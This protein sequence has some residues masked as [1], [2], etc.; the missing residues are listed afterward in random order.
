[1]HPC[2]AHLRDQESCVSSGVNDEYSSPQRN[3]KASTRNGKGYELH[4][5]PA[6]P[7]NF[8]QNQIHQPSRI[9]E[10][11]DA[12]AR[13]TDNKSCPLEKDFVAILNKIR[14]E[15]LKMHL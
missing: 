8:V 9:A 4:G 2:Q 14:F 3:S 13:C 10:T 6:L 12:L 1:M 7:G 5:K 15:S 11:M